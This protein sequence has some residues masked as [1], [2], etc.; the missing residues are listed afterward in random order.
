[1]PS[2]PRNDSLSPG[3]AGATTRDMNV[4]VVTNM[5]PSAT[6]PDWGAFVR[7]QTESLGRLGVTNHLYEI[8]GW[9]SAL[10]YAVAWRELPTITARERVDLVHAHY[11]LSGAAATRVHA[12]LVVS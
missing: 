1:V 6:R 11:G 3:G 2:L 12:P 8:E 5:Y 9:K 4:L 10:R 7:S